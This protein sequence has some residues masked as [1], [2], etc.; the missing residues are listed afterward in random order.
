[1][2]RDMYFAL[3]DRLEP[4]LQRKKQYARILKKNVFIMDSTIIPLSMSLFDWAKFRTKKGA[5]KLHA[6]LDYD[7]GLPS[8]A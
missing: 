5:V 6:V 4:S 3:L 1:M 8:Y 2:F 7:T